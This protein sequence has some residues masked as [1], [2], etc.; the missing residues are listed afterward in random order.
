MSGT[1]MNQSVRT[2][3]KTST[4]V[5]N[6]ALTPTEAVILA[7]AA[8]IQFGEL[9]DVEVKAENAFVLMNLSAAQH[10]FVKTIRK[11]GVRYL[12]SITIHNGYPSQIEIEGQFDRIH[13]RRKIRFT[14]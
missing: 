11:E 5:L 4:S 1:Y 13:Y 14:Q 8:E 10:A 7:A 12:D 9:L 2:L 3:D 6:F